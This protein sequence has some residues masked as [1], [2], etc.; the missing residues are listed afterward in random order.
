MLGVGQE[1]NQNHQPSNA[2]GPRSKPGPVHSALGALWT[3]TLVRTAV[4]LPGHKKTSLPARLDTKTLSEKRKNKLQLV[5]FTI[6]HTIKDING[7]N[8][9][10]KP[11]SHCASTRSLKLVNCCTGWCA[12]LD[13]RPSGG[14]NVRQAARTAGRVQSQWRAPC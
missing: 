7:C 8:T 11:L 5:R 13:A 3:L 4:C 12:M 9:C 14:A 1:G 10:N 6:Y 2:L